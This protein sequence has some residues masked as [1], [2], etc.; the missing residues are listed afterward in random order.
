[1]MTL[2]GAAPAAAAAASAASTAASAALICDGPGDINIGNRRLV[3]CCYF[4]DWFDVLLLP[5]MIHI[6]PTSQATA[7]RRPARRPEVTLFHAPPPPIFYCYPYSSTTWVMVTFH[8]CLGIQQGDSASRST[9]AWHRAA[10]LTTARRCATD[11]TI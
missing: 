7:G 3:S 10:D 2:R 11:L 5:G 8:Y 4:G 6:S 1:M 9:P